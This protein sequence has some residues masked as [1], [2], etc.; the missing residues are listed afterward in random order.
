M[1]SC[2]TCFLYLFS[3][4]FSFAGLS[5][6]SG[7]RTSY[8]N[9]SSSSLYPRGQTQGVTLCSNSFTAKPWLSQPVF[10]VVV[11]DRVS[12]CSPGWPGTWFV[13]WAG[14]TRIPRLFLCFETGSC[15]SSGPSTKRPGV[16]PGSWGTEPTRDLQPKSQRV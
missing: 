1:A 12:L 10:V 2:A 14:L 8:R 3:V 5:C 7:L 11:S 9:L 13:A 16:H 15:Y 4:C 6:L